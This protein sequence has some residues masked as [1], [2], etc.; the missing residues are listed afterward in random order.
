M[1]LSLSIK[2][3][4]SQANSQWFYSI[5]NSQWFRISL[6]SSCVG[7][8]GSYRFKWVNDRITKVID[9]RVAEQIKMMNIPKKIKLNCKQKKHKNQQ[10]V[11]W[12]NQKS[13]IEFIQLK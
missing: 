5:I 8:V 6:C 7:G 12:K 3:N 9:V 4:N 1:K 10:N 2:S 13:V 11:S